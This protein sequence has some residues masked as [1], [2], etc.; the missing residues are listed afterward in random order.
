MKCFLLQ[1]FITIRSTTAVATITQSEP[2]WL[3]LAAFRDVVFWLDAR[4]QS[5]SMQLTYQTA[6]AKDDS[7]FTNVA[8]LTPATGVTVTPILQDVAAAPL[9]RWLRWQLSGASADLTFRIWVAAN[10]P[11]RR[12][13]TRQ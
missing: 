7:L 8:I 13:L 2:G 3:D 9:A 5:G 11:G 12:N 6:V 1:D 10:K 4:E